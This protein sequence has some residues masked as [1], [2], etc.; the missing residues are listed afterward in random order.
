[1]C[2]VGEMVKKLHMRLDVTSLNPCTAYT[3]FDVH[4]CEGAPGDFQYF[5]GALLYKLHK[6]ML[7]L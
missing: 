6:I 4:V 7:L 2:C 3:Y 1:M 5:C